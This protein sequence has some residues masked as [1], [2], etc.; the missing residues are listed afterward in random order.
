MAFRTLP[1]APT[2]SSRKISSSLVALNT[3]DRRLYDIL[4]TDLFDTVLL[5]DHTTESQRLAISCHRAARSLGVD[6]TVVVRLRWDLHGAAY[7][8]VSFERPAGEAALSSIC[9][10]MAAAL[11]LGTAAEETLHR[12]EVD[13]DIEHLRPNRA[14]LR[15]FDSLTAAG[16]RVVAVSD[17]YY[18]TT[19]LHRILD[20]V[21]GR[22]SIAAVYGSADLGL[23]KHAGSIFREVARRET[24]A[25]ER[26]LHIGDAL[27][28]DV[29]RAREAS[30]QAMHYPRG[31]GHRVA[32]LIGAALSFPTTRARQR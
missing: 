29:L 23:T 22:H 27:G 13:V 2:E 6:P 20:A 15:S 5:R 9:A 12:T 3:F 7:R 11:G 25:P 8:A 24:T 10:T 1:P 32:K 17:T 19:D 14:L 4:S 28:S 26:F 31:G 30:W 18:S 16:G 21:V